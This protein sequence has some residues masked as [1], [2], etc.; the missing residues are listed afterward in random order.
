MRLWH[1]TLVHSRGVPYEVDQLPGF[2]ALLD[3]A[4]VGHVAFAEAAERE[5]EVVTI[6]S[7]IENRGVGTALLDAAAGEARRTTG[8]RTPSRH[9][10]STAQAE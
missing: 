2:I 9:T 7:C 5:T 6:A 8:A 10:A 3:G 1:S 4:R